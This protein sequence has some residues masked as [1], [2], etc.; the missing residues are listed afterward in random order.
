MGTCKL[1]LGPIRL[2]L[3]GA[4]WA[5]QHFALLA[6][7]GGFEPPVPV[8]Q[9][10]CLAGSPVQPLQHLSSADRVLQIQLFKRPAL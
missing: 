2:R 9:H 5:G 8:T 3:L 4:W 10:N 6:E 7:R 1:D